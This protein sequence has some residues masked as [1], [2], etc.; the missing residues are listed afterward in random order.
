M[1][2]REYD[3]WFDKIFKEMTKGMEDHDFKG[4]NHS[5]G[6]YIHSKEHYKMEMKRRRMVPTDIA[7]KMADEWD[8][9]NP[10]A[11]YDEL[12]P[13][14]MDIIRSLKMSADSDGN[15]IIGTAG[16][17][18]L[19]ELGWMPGRN[20]HAPERITMSGGFKK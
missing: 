8:K 10:N 7:M 13:K 14:A 11:N 4:P 12:T 3:S 20:P 16:I 9:K 6:I 5:M 2:D 1:E 19:K 17:R 15:V 18:A